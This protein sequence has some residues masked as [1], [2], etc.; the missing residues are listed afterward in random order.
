MTTFM[1]KMKGFNAGSNVI[2]PEFKIIFNYLVKNSTYDKNIFYTKIDP[3]KK[4][5]ANIIRTIRKNIASI[6]NLMVINIQTS[7]H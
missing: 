7:Y 2:T 4:I 3:I 5:K 6:I 1:E